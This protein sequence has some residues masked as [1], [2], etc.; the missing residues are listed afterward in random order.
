M[1]SRERLTAGGAGGGGARGP[2]WEPPAPATSFVGRERELA[3]LR[4]RLQRPDVR[5]LVLTGPG[6]VGKTRLALEA[7]GRAAPGQAAPGRAAPGRG[8]ADGS[9][10][11]DG[12]VFVPLA[13]ITS[14]RLVIPAIGTALGVRGG[15]RRA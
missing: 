11:P 7:A 12:V 8:R 13:G 15:G 10:F 3:T 14:A 4:E 6:G 9:P 1:V 2:V 5:L